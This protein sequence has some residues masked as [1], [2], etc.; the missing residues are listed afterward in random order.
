MCGIVGFVGDRE[1]APV[2]L[3][4]LTKLEYRGYDSAGVATISD[5]TVHVRKD[6]GK[7]SDVRE[8]HR[9]WTLPGQVGIG[10]VRWATHG[11]VT[12]TNAHPHLDF[13]RQIAIVHN[14]NIENYQD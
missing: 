3:N 13:R 10:H 1:A 9:L 2:I 5:S 11:G 7:L 12:A 8:K 6:V 14:G 4:T